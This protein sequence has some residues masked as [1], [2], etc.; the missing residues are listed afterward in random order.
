LVNKKLIAVIFF[1]S[2]S[3]GFTQIIESP[4]NDF[5]NFFKCGGDLFSEPARFDAKDWITFSSTIGLTTA[6]FLVDEDIRKI[7]LEN[8]GYFGDV[9]FKI[10]DYYHIE[11]MVASIAALY[12]YGVTAKNQDVRNLG[13]KLTEATV[14]SGTITLLS[15]VL[16]GRER[17]ASSSDVLSFNPPNSSWEFTSLPSGHSTLSFAYST[18]MASV[19]NNFFWKF[20]WYSLAALVGTARVYHNAHWFSDVLFGA[21]IGYFVG[22]FVNNH[23][24]NQKERAGGESANGSPDFSI[25][26]GFAF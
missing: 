25:S 20:G 22:D 9:V 7:A 18:V 2:S 1:L 6:S 10:D 24:T 17:P 14:Y 19:Y 3:V 16:F 13:M 4:K 21:A 26:F 12:V 23:Y 5:K 15:K 8:Q 11:F